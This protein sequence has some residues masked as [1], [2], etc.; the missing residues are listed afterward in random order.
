MRHLICSLIGSETSKLC[1]FEANNDKEIQFQIV[2]GCKSR[3][4]KRRA[5][6]DETLDLAKLLNLGRT[7]EGVRKQLAAYVD[8][9]RKDDLSSSEE[10][11]NDGNKV[12]M[13]KRHFQNNRQSTSNNTQYAAKSYSTNASND[14]YFDKTAQNKMKEDGKC[15][16]CGGQ[17]PH[18]NNKS[19][20]AKDVVCY[21]CNNTGHYKKYCFARRKDS[22]DTSAKTKS[23][24]M[25]RPS[26]SEDAGGE[27]GYERMLREVREFNISHGIPNGHSRQRQQLSQPGGQPNEVAVSQN[28]GPALRQNDN[29]DD[30]GVRR[31]SRNRR[32]PD[33]YDALRFLYLVGESTGDDQS[34]YEDLNNEPQE[35]MDF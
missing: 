24:K 26:T 12:N 31:S 3:N 4:L 30:D 17:F 14:Y 1:N 6:A 35:L 21:K 13:L 28:E 2:K 32:A 15:F 20:P 5:L 19:C 7:E 18:A 22:N 25:A 11:D 16:R 27:T 29:Q 10:S 23:S 9:S 34:D 8:K 33:R